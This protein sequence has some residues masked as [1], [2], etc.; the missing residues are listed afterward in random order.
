MIREGE[1]GPKFKEQEYP[2][3]KNVE[4]E[5]QGL[6]FDPGS[7][8]QGR[9]AHPGFHTLPARFDGDVTDKYAMNYPVSTS[10]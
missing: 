5:P 10:N 1:C 7:K 4:I 3:P 8:I 9:Y 6:R 2:E